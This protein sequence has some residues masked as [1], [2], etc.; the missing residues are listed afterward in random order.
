MVPPSGIDPLLRAP[1]TRVLPL[2]QGGVIGDSDGSR[3]RDLSRDRRVLSQLSYKANL[4]AGLG[5]APRSGAYETPEVLLLY[6]AINC[7][8]FIKDNPS[9]S[10]HLRIIPAQRRRRLSIV[11]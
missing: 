8:G 1:Q 7:D 5:F 2:H 11:R 10:Y 3:S 4:V 6:P 9:N